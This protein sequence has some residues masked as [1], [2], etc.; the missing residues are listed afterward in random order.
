MWGNFGIVFVCIVGQFVGEVVVVYVSKMFFLRDVVKVIYFC[1][2]NLVEEKN[3][4]MIVIQNCKVE[5]I[6]EKCS[7]FLIGKVN[8]V[9]Y[10]SLLLFVVFGDVSVIEELKIIFIGYQVKVIFLNV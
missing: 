4:K 9:V 2:I 5:V 10:Y 3:G 7:Q 6:E 8:V 1:L